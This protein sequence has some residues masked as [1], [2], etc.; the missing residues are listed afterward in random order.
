[1]KE[2]FAVKVLKNYSLIFDVIKN[3]DRLVDS[4]PHIE[5]LKIIKYFLNGGKQQ[6][7]SI[8]GNKFFKKLLEIKNETK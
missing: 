4:I 1:M 6:K 3:N 5:R 2:D 7:F 8:T